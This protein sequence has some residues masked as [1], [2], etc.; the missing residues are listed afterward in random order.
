MDENRTDS[1]HQ[2]VKITIPDFQAST[3]IHP[4]SN[5]SRVRSTR[6][7]ALELHWHSRTGNGKV[8]TKYGN[9]CVQIAKLN[10][11]QDLGKDR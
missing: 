10:Y 5:Y 11:A 9:V 2:G 8:I 1:L 6:E 3:S 7:E 4:H